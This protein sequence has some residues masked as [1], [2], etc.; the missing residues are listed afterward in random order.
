MRA[1]PQLHQFLKSYSQTILPQG[2]RKTRVA[3]LDNGIIG[4]SLLKHDATH[5]TSV[6]SVFD[7]VK[8]GESFIYDVGGRKSAW[9]MA[10]DAAHGTQMASL[11]S[12][13]DPRCEIFIAQVS[14]GRHEVTPDRVEQV[15]YAN[16]GL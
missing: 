4:P 14:N 16:S 2:S 12:A 15:R 13:L 8:S 7:Q 9:Y 11:V 6:Q 1:F 10:R 3:I 5:P